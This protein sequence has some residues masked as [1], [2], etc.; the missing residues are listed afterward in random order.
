M[1]VLSDPMFMVGLLFIGVAIIGT[2][3]KVLFY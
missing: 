1:R 3:L 2:V